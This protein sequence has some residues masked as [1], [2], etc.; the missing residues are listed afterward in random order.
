[1]GYRV[2]ERGLK[3]VGE[4]GAGAKWSKGKERRCDR[5]GGA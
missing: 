4:R 3:R 1:M 2:S 5:G